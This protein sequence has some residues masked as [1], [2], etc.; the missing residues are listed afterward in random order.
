M[1]RATNNSVAGTDARNASRTALRPET[2]SPLGFS[3][4]LP[5]AP[6]V[7]VRFSLAF[8]RLAAA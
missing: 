2:I 6:A 3:V 4:R 5:R 8:F 1:L 7:G